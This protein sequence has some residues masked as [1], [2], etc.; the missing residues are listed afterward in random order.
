MVADFLEFEKPGT[1]KWGADPADE[2]VS[3][4]KQ[5]RCGRESKQWRRRRTRVFA[6]H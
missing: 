5:I 2:S 6:L 4:A 3:V 1:R